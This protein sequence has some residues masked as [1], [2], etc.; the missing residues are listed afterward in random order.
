MFNIYLK[1]AI[2]S[3]KKN[4]MHSFINITGLTVGIACCML[5]TLFVKDE[6]SYDQY[7][8][9]Y[10]EIYRVLHA[11]R[12]MT[13]SGKLPPPAPS[14]YQ[15]WG[16][17]PVGPV[18]KDNFPEVMS[19]TQFT[20]PRTIL[21]EHNDARFQETS[22]LFADASIFDVFSWNFITGDSKTA[23][24]APNAI[25][26]TKSMAQKYFGTTNIVG[27]TIKAEN[28][29]LNV[30]GVMED[31]PSN[32]HFTFTGLISMET[33]KRQR[34][35]IFSQ[36]GYVDF[37]TYIRTV[38][39][40]NIAA[41]E[42]KIPGILK[43]HNSDIHDENYTFTFEPLKDAYLFSQ[44]AR[45]PGVTGSL[46]N[47]VIFSLIAIFMLVI[48]AINFVNLS[49]ARSLERAK[50][51]G[52]RKAIGAQE[53]TLIIQ[54]LAEAIL[55]TTF[56]TILAIA[57]CFVCLPILRQLA[58]K[59]LPMQLMWSKEL[60]LL[61]FLTPIL[62]GIPAG[63]YPALV[64]AK[65][66]PVQVLKGRFTSSR[67]GLQLRRGL[68]V[69]QFS[70][71]IALIASTAIVYSQLTHLQQHSLG[72]NNEQLLVIDYGGDRQINKHQDAIKLRLAQQPDVKAISISRAVPGD[73]FPDGGT[74]IATP[75]GE[76][77]AYNLSMYEIDEDFISTF[78]IPMMAGRSYSKS[79]P[80]DTAQSLVINEATAKLYGY[81]NPQDIIGK[82]FEQW[83]R[84]GV[85]IGV[86]KDFN[87]QSLHEKVKPL[88]LRRGDYDA[89]NKITL[90]LQSPDLRKTVKEIEAIW[91]EVAPQRP[92]L[93][94]F[95]DQAFNRQYQKDQRF[96]Q[97]F[98]IFGLLTIF[99]ACLGLFGLVT[100]SI[101]KRIKE[102]GIRR[103][104]GA[105]IP[106]VIGLLSHDFI[107]LILIAIAIATP[108]SWYA[109][110]NWLNTFAYSVDIHWWIFALAGVAAMTIAIT[111]IGILA[112]R[113][114]RVNPV[115]ALRTE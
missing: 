76:T 56:A 73:Q 92:F 35:E 91:N 80:A 9:H 69:F 55:L 82:P 26:L 108:I 51:I 6:L 32:S 22:L 48:A 104:L 100:Y 31:V 65:F 113:A 34:A 94:S 23:L 1:T 87:F 2:R 74:V 45:Q 97:I 44:A 41:M 20:S 77:A 17:A 13:G 88:A 52:V 40:V 57:L 112:F 7:N 10:N 8:Q 33:F 68:V 84:K 49:T 86:V 28:L 78:K 99:I 58:D 24:V 43:Q 36:W 83:G 79:F 61:Y 59:G 4:R 102:I 114:A 18:L 12:P 50:E 115:D 109:M 75:T 53:S 106:N 70:L 111:T 15:V 93:Y 110:H 98:S 37:Y 38:P 21:M 47:I 67:K 19:V 11:Y 62:V 30:T 54:Y 25:V 95:L 46:S 14:E 16:N 3:I 63:I 39:N 29:I 107:L 42:A 60:I 81:A 66:K 101:E 85:V 27:Q 71:S 64:L 105:S 89:F 90:R 72:F 5:I 96:G 103:T